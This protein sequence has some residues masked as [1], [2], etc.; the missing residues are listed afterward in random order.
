MTFT[1]WTSA[2]A[3]AHIAVPVA[4]D[5]KYSRG[6]LG[7]VTGSTQYPGA[8]VLGVESAL[9][10]GVGMVRYLGPERP[11]QLVL[12]RRPEVVTSTGRVQ[13][14]LL[15]SG[16][17]AATRDEATTARLT[18]AL[19]LSLPTVI[20]AGALDLL[21]TASGPVIITPHFGE[22]SRV[23]GIDKDDIAGDPGGSAARAADRLGVT[24]LLKGAR[25]Y[26]AD[27]HG[28]RLVV[29]S[30]TAWTATAGSGDAL[31]GILGAI[32]ATHSA[33]IA[34]DAGVLACLGATAAVLH[35][36]AAKRASGGGP[37]TV[38]DLA[39]ELSNAVAGLLAV[40]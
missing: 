2:D 3:A 7:I 40:S 16:M 32:V 5:D 10:T 37:F 21:D 6:V 31:G 30:D 36:L 35:G 34:A 24:V 9:R 25:T 4:S 33:E 22:L 38:L 29:T 13:G 12:Q 39:G 23:L 28:T 26:L 19:A 11:S 14:W 1:E 27:P 20:D 17:D 8:A 15:G 18:D